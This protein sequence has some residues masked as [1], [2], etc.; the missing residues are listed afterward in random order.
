MTRVEGLTSTP[1][2]ARGGSQPPPGASTGVTRRNFLQVVG[3]TALATGAATLLGACSR[4]EAPNVQFDRHIRI[5][6]V[7][8]LTGAQG[9]F[10]EGET[11]TLNKIR[12]AL[13]DGLVID[14]D[15]YGVDIVVKDSQTAE[16]RAAQVAGDLIDYHKVDMVLVMSDFVGT[17]IPTADLCEQRGVPCLSTVGSWNT[18]VKQRGHTLE[19][20]FKWTYHFYWGHPEAVRVFMDMWQGLDTNRVVAGL[21]PDDAPGKEAADPTTG[22][23]GAL[24]RNHYNVVDLGRYE[25]QNNTRLPDFTKLIKQIADTKADILTGNP[26]GGD[27]IE[28]WKQLADKRAIPPYVTISRA[29]NFARQVEAYTP[30]ADGIS[31]STAW[32]ASF[33]FRSSLTGVTAKQYSDAYTEDTGRQPLFTL[34]FGHALWEVAIDV[35]KRAGG[36]GNR[37][38][39]VEAIKKTKLD[40]ILGT[41]D[42]TNPDNPHPNIARMP[43]VGA[44]WKAGDGEQFK[45][46]L[47]IV[48]NRMLPQVP[49]TGEFTPI[50]LTP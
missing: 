48:S 45:F 1:K 18:Y 43:L 11:Y 41:V 31:T 50:R 36:A 22:Y 25:N 7:V 29:A 8:P 35:L 30:S 19:Q 28:M 21:W 2:P 9:S 5:G 14:G 12:T 34:G 23:P 17:L 26:L 40:T 37:E 49:V 10:A 42:F 44:Q 3:G 47:V 16:G 33:P 32:H 27:F 6:Y 46:E 13:R 39:V 15:R 38:A 24:R 4:P 20:P